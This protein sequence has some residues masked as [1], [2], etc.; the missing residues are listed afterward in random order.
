MGPLLMGAGGRGG[1]SKFLS[2]LPEMVVAM[3]FDSEGISV[4][5]ESRVDFLEIA[6]DAWPDRVSWGVA[7]GFGADAKFLNEGSDIRGAFHGKRR[8]TMHLNLEPLLSREGYAK[9]MANDQI[10]AG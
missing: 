7:Y 10:S 5:E 2:D 4:A 1:V 3:V 9:M 6:A 8:I